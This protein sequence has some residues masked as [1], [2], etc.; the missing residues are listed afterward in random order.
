MDPLR[1]PV[2]SNDASGAVAPNQGT[3]PPGDATGGMD[4]HPTTSPG[5]DAGGGMDPHHEPS[6]ASD[7]GGGFDP[8]Y[9]HPPEN[10]DYSGAVDVYRPEPGAD[11]D[12]EESGGGP[13][14]TFLEHLEDLRW[15]IVKCTIAIALGVI[16]CL[17][18]GK[19]IVAIVGWPLQQAKKLR[20][21]PEVRVVISLGTNFF[22]RVPVRDFPFAG[23]STNLDTYLRLAPITLGGQTIL[24]LVADTNPPISSTDNMRLDLKVYSPGGGFVIAMQIA[25]FGGM[26]LSAPF[27]LFFIGQFVLPAMHI[28]EKKFL[29]RVSGF[30]TLLF[31]LGIAFCYFVMLPITFSTTTV[32]SNW[33]GFAADEWKADDY[34]S[35]TCWFLLG[36]GISFELPLVL[37]TLVKIGLLTSRQ[38]NQFRM[39]WVVAGLVISGFVTPDGNPLTMLLMFLPLHLLYEISVVIAW[40]WGRKERA[41]E[42]TIDT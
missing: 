26:T 13:V 3:P 32:F 29:F 12:E 42:A 6:S 1:E 33:I 23:A 19:Q 38:L 16:I 7:A 18:A 14:K 35:F 30:A 20:T 9:E 27:V 37:L 10:Q 11:S 15:T 4:S 36:M 5:S 2:P 41:A 40:F 25:I 39:Y 22:A 28:H 8:H 17:S 24:G 21:D 31:F 34:I